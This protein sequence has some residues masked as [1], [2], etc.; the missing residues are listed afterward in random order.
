MGSQ[1]GWGG[2]RE[3]APAGVEK[4][5][6]PVSSGGQEGM[7]FLENSPLSLQLPPA[8]EHG[9]T[10]RRHGSGGQSWMDKRRTEGVSAETGQS[11]GHREG[12]S[13]DR[14]WRRLLMRRADSLEKTLMLGKT[15][16]R[17]RW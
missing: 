13:S 15:E 6:R 8:A 3:A 2:G 10:A 16:S 4:A 5:G 12:Q 1:V 9:G 11:L 17:R 14:S 7:L